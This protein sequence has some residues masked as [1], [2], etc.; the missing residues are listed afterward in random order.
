MVLFH[1]NLF[2][3]RPC[4]SGAVSQFSRVRSALPFIATILYEQQKSKLYDPPPPTTPSTSTL[5][6]TQRSAKLV[7]HSQGSL[8][9]VTQSYDVRN[10]KNSANP[11]E[12][13]QEALLM[14]FTSLAVLLS[15]GQRHIYILDIVSFV[16]NVI[17]V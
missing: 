7:Y 10:G 3:S 16:L 13:M 14:A 17:R 5:P 2:H 4:D 6:S 11:V 9:G 15:S 8:S 1:L 12:N